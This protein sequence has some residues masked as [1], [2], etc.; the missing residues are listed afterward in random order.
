VAEVVSQIDVTTLHTY[1]QNNNLR[2][3]IPLS[4]ATGRSLP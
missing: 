2:M 4:R 1:I 3:A